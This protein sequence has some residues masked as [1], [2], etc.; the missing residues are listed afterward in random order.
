MSAELLDRIRADGLLVA[1]DPPDTIIVKG[2]PETRRRWLPE[3]REH[4]PELLRL[5]SRPS[6]R[7][8]VTH[9]DGTVADHTTTPHATEPEMRAAYPDAI[10][11]EPL[12]FDARPL[13]QIRK[14]IA[15]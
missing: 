5:L 3:I 13:D 4:K 1:L 8:L 9:P 12:G 7:W 11:F 15:A 6:W 10:G 14:E 2:D